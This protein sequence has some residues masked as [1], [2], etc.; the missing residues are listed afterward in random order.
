[1][2]GPAGEL[3]RINLGSFRPYLVTHPRHVQHVP[4]ERSENYERADDGLSWRAVERQFGEGILGEGRQIGSAR[5]KVLQPTFTAKR[6]EALLD[7]MAEAIRESVDDLDKPSRDGRTVDI[8]VEQTRTMSAYV[9]VI[10]SIFHVFDAL[11]GLDDRQI[12]QETGAHRA[13]TA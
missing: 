5:R 7:G 6:I 2:T 3:V 13:R 1:M 11:G 10:D 8:E 9:G 12:T 4:R